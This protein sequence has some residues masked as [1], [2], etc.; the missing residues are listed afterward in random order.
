VQPVDEVERLP[1]KHV[2]FYANC[3]SSVEP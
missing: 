1:R 3:A 2:R